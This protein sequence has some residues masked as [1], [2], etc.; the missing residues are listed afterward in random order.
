MTATE[1]RTRGTVAD[2]LWDLHTDTLDLMS[3]KGLTYRQLTVT[4]TP[5]NFLRVDVTVDSEAELQAWGRAFFERGTP[6]GSAG[7]TWNVNLGGPS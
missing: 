7:I 1:A 2:R 4:R 5:A 6:G 3:W